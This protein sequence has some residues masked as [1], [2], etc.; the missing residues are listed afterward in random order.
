MCLCV[1]VCVCV[2]GSLP[3]CTRRGKS[4]GDG[5]ELGSAATLKSSQPASRNLAARQ[6]QGKRGAAAG[7]RGACVNVRV[8]VGV[9]LTVHN[10]VVD[11]P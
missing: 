1:C 2:Q 7:A 4:C 11:K 6:S 9:S 3:A 8:R 10:R 5:F